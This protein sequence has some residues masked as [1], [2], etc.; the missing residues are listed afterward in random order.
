MGWWS[1]NIMGGDT[2]LDFQSKV[3]EELG[4]S[5]FPNGFDGDE[6]EPTPED[7]N[8]N[9]NLYDKL[10]TEE[11]RR[12]WGK[13]SY[14][15]AKQ[16]FA[17]M[18]MKAGGKMTDEVRAETTQ[19]CDD[20]EWANDDLERAAHIRNLKSHIQNYDHSPVTNL[21]QDYGVF[22]AIQ[23]GESPQLDLEVMKVN[24]EKEL[25]ELK[26]EELM[27]YETANIQINAPRSLIQLST[28]T[29]INLLEKYLNLPISSFPLVK[30]MS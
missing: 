11:F 21:E 25:Q 13:D 3:Y 22:G 2:P 20:D 29:K 18:L 19:A 17:Y 5:Q 8:S 7:F 6:Y 26:N 30:E 4:K 1:T 27:Y 15:I 24:M 23:Q 9:P 12:N 10:F 14:N 28:G 16:V